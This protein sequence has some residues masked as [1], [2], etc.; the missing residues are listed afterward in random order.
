MA[1]L[2][3]VAGDFFI[4]T[5][6]FFFFF[7]PHKTLSED[8]RITITSLVVNETIR[9]RRGKY[10]RVDHSTGRKRGMA[11]VVFTLP[12]FFLFSFLFRPLWVGRKGKTKNR[13]KLLDVSVSLVFCHLYSLLLPL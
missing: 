12:P 2:W 13:Y 11:G 1:R 3:A 9:T 8:N 10:F 6:R 5:S 7:F 4:P